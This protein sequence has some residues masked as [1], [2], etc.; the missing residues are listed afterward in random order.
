MNLRLDWYGTIRSA[1]T[2]LI[3]TTCAWHASA[4]SVY[5][6]RPVVVRMAYPAGGPAD[7]ALRDVLPVLQREIGQ[8]VVVE[9]MPGANGS[10]A[11]MNVQNAAADGYTLL[12]T[13]TSDLILAPLII[14]T[15]KYK[16]QAFQP[17]GLLGS[18]DLVLLSGPAHDFRSADQLI[19][20]A[21]SS[22]KEMSI[23]NWGA[24]SLTHVAAADFAV[25]GG[26]KLLH[27]PYKGAA[28]IIPDL[29]SGQIDLS[30][31]PMGG[32]IV[33]LIKAGIVK[34][35]AIA[36]DKRNPLL[37]DVPTI[38]ESKHFKDFTYAA[39]SAVFAPPGTPE[40][41]IARLNK[42]MNVY[43]A[44]AEGRA[45]Q[46]TIGASPL[47]PLSV[48]QMNELF[49]AESATM[50]RAANATKLQVGRQEGRTE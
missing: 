26:I 44:S 12:G 5:P 43:I 24:G 13:V 34:P 11:A 37:P 9:N 39:R 7:S 42:A 15:A 45:R 40:A 27:V 3:L 47:E 14:P 41:V 48:K 4:Q 23:G 21:K 30:F 36:A 31:A 17:V 33:G 38:N 16:P 29:G 32:S 22:G 46:V 2:V 18:G 1:A 19:E 28:P 35:V 6:N 20:Y 49:Q 50:T 8:P 10:I 25:R